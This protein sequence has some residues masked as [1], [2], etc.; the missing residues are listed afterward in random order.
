MGQLFNK[1]K[2]KCHD[3]GLNAHIEQSPALARESIIS[4]THAMA[5]Y[6][7]ALAELREHPVLEPSSGIL[8]AR[9]H[10]DPARSAPFP[11]P[12]I[13]GGRWGFGADCGVKPTDFSCPIL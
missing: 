5:Q 8:R 4:S 13:S 9:C 12:K 2:Y 10:Y 6:G 1:G 3:V 11:H 7:A